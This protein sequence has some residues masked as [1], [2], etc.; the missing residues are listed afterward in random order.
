MP[1]E[2]IQWSP[3]HMAKTRRMI[4]EM[5]PEVDF[6]IELCDARIPRSSSNPDLTKLEGAKPRLLVFTKTDLSDPA[7]TSGWKR[8]FQKKEEP[9]CF[10]NL[11]ERKTVSEIRE[12]VSVLMK[13]KTD[14]YRLSGMTGRPLRALVAGIPNVGKSTLLNLLAGQKKAKTED[15]PGVTRDKQWINASAEAG[16]F[17]LLDT[18]G[19]LWP[20]FDDQTIGENLAFTGAIRDEILDTE[21]LAL[22]LCSRLASSYPEKLI[23]RYKITLPD[24]IKDH[25]IFDAIAKKRGYIISHGEIDS[26]RTS[27]MLLNEFREAKI[28]RISL[29][30]PQC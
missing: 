13:E 10:V 11:R 15:R 5:L 14:K 1:S 17:E 20:K 12:A 6:V 28:G 26:E 7:V 18:P 24:G 3:G 27:V 29:E 2:I 30:A 4:R 21:R 8:Y 25:E 23:E 9:A 16:G 19:V 22:A